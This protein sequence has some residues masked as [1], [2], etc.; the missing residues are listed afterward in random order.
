MLGQ[1]ERRV[2]DRVL[3]DPVGELVA[4]PVERVALEADLD[5]GAQGV[6]VG[7]V[8]EGPDEVV[9]EL[10]LDLLAE[11]AEVD[12]EM[13][14]LAGQ[15]GLRVVVGEGDVELG[16]AADLEADQV[17]LEARDQALLAEDQR[18]PVGAAALERLAVPRPDERDDRVVAVAR[19]AVLDRG[20]RRVLVPQLLDDL[21]DP[22]VVD[23]LDLRLEVEV[24]VVAELDLGRHLDGRLEDE[25]LALLGLDHLDVRVGQRH[26]VLLD[27]RLAVAVAD[28]VLDGL[29]EDD[30]RAEVP[31]EDRS[32]SLAG[33]EAGDARV[34]R[35]PA[36]GVVDGAA[37][38][39]RGKLD[40]EQDR[41]IRGR[42]WR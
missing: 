23:G 24:L 13:R 25:R 31:L 8:A 5:V 27:H 40:F 14:L 16:R 3:D 10:G 42:V 9:V 17:G 39:F 11:L 12:R 36:D 34:A 33:A 38:T 30:A 2:G 41:W 15:L 6:E 18:H 21:V 29:V 20:E 32:R 35:Q 1:L 28:E 37:Q 4:G 19:P 7:E 26:E 22:G